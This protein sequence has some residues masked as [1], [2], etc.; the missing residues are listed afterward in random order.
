MSYSTSARYYDLDYQAL[1]YNR[2]IPFYV[3]MARESGGP[4]LEMG[5]G[6]GR[7]LIPTARAGIDIHGLEL[8]PDMLACLAASLEREPAEVRR[9]VSFAQ[10]DMRT[11]SLERRFPLITAPFRVVQHL[12]TR[13]DQRA[14]LRTVR[15]H[16]APHGRLVFDVFQP[17][18]TLIA[19][20]REPWVELE[21][22]D[23]E[24]GARIRR[25][26]STRNHPASQTIDITFRWERQVASG[27]WLPDGDS[28][29]TIRWYTHAELLNLLEL[30]GLEVAAEW[31]SF[32]R[33][34]FGEDSRDQILVARANAA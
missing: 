34:P 6:T 10:G 4:V 22:D 5:C 24:T 31:G 8:S 2:D 28:R 13:D 20:A 32:D 9:H 7:T 15:R 33:Q 27:G 29:L 17:D 25:V 14:W 12:H 16:L 1:G 26:A 3:G 18:Y 30:E 21:R 19:A 23:P 11:A